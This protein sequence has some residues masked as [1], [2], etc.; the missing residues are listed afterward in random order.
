MKPLKSGKGLKA[1]VAAILG[2]ATVGALAMPVAAAEPEPKQ[3][4]VPA[5]VKTS[6]AALADDVDP[7]LDRITVTFD[8]PMMD[9]NWSWTGG[10]ETY[11]RITG[12]ISYDAAKTT[13]TLP[14]KL[15]PGKVYWVGVNSPSHRNFKTP[16][17][18][19]AAW[20]VI[21]FATK[22]ADGNPTPIPEEMLVRAKRINARAKEKREP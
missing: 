17:R 15:E 7:A 11:P 16:D 12:K 18:I 13:C 22:S 10:G 1:P 14:V 19:P 8:Q 20:H 4:V 21:V 2:L 3:G 5:V 9:Q 6:P